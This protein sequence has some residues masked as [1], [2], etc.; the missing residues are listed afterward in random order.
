[1]ST[2]LGSGN[3]VLLQEALFTPVHSSKLSLA[4]NRFNDCSVQVI[5]ATQPIQLSALSPPPPCPSPP[6]SNPS[7]P[8]HAAGALDVC[9]TTTDIVD[10][11]DFSIEELLKFWFIAVIVS[12]PLLVSC[13][14]LSC[15]ACILFSNVV[16]K[17]C[18]KLA[19]A[20]RNCMIS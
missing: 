16:I 11:M 8:Q 4:N 5:Q 10:L 9:T 7:P 14:V 20:L 12:M 15:M 3:K 19:F 1:M 13:S 6:Q 2:I 17:N 18:T